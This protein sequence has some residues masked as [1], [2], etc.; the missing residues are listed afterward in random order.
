M[1]PIPTPRSR[2]VY[3]SLLVV[4]AGCAA[5]AP[6]PNWQREVKRLL[7]LGHYDRAI[8]L[9]TDKAQSAEEPERNAALSLLFGAR[10]AQLQRLRGI[11]Q[12]EDALTAERLL[13]DVSRYRKL[14]E[15]AELDRAAITHRAGFDEGF[16]FTRPELRAKLAARVSSLE[17]DGAELGLVFR[18]LFADTG[19]NILVD[20]EVVAG[21]RITLS[22][23]DASVAEILE[24]VAQ[25]HGLHYQLRDASVLVRAAGQVELVTRA[26]R[27][28]RGLAEWDQSSAFNS[29]GDL[30]LLVGANQ[31]AGGGGGGPARAPAPAGGVIA[32]GD[33]LGSRS[34]LDLLVARLPKLVEWPPAAEIYLD[35][36]HNL[37]VVRSSPASLT[38]IGKLLDQVDGEQPQILIE[39]RYLEVA[40]DDAVDL[41]AEWTVDRRFNDPVLGTDAA[42]NVALAGSAGPRSGDLSANTRGRSFFGLPTVGGVTTGSELSLVGVFNE[43]VIEAVVYAL[44]RLETTNT[45]ATPHVIAAN[46]SRAQ[47]AIV[48]N[49]A[50]IESFEI[51]PGQVSQTDNTVLTT[52][53]TVRA[54]VND[55][56]YTGVLLNVKPSIGADGRTI[57]IVLQPVIREQVDTITIDNGAI[58]VDNGVEI[59]TPPLTRPILETR[60]TTTQLSIADGATIVL[61]G[62]VTARD[63]VAE[64]KVPVLGDIPGLG[65]LF[66][67][68]TTTRQKRNLLI[69]VTARIVNPQGGGYRDPPTPPN[70]PPRPGPAEGAR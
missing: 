50:F 19:I 11:A 66:R 51:I 62:L 52:P 42:G 58:I 29:L 43:T 16:D 41:G 22:V 47:I 40:T 21:K 48:R 24:H 34:F 49:L 9:A 56:N 46:N 27:L 28:R 18:Q 55:S 53:T 8:E 65:W 35:R 3:L 32:P 45:L 69:F 23:K 6:E 39:T 59:S 12:I 36:Q 13:L 30:G 31:A 37:L 17:L 68:Q 54:F 70:V 15:T 60:L 33:E 67:R 44:S 7:D 2:A 10:V 57:H 4:T 26:F 61:G 14:P 63:V 64:N 5:F 38:Q 1:T 20:P 25:V